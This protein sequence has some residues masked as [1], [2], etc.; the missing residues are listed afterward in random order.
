MR[1]R[2]FTGH[3]QSQSGVVELSSAKART[4]PASEVNVMLAPLPISSPIAGAGLV[5][6]V[7]S[8]SGSSIEPPTMNSANPITPTPKALPRD[9]CAKRNGLIRPSTDHPMIANPTRIKTPAAISDIHLSRNARRLSYP[10][11]GFGRATSPRRRTMALFSHVPPTR[12]QQVELLA[13]D[14]SQ[15]RRCLSI[16]IVIGS[17]QNKFGPEHRFIRGDRH[18]IQRNPGRQRRSR[19]KDGPTELLEIL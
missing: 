11:L 6:G 18:A 9:P 14:Y 19:R 13:E 12:P 10:R 7:S 3:A 17:A 5:A 2:G 15:A 1:L 8:D 16:L 4:R